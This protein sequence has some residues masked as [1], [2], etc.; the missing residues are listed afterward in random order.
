[1]L[2]TA[3]SGQINRLPGRTASQS[4]QFVIYSSDRPLRSRVAERAEA[5]RSAWRSALGDTDEWKYPIVINF[6]DPAPGRTGEGIVTGIY[7]ADNNALKVQVDVWDP[8]RGDRHDFTV[9]IV[10]ALALERT[11]RKNP[12]R[13]GA[14]FR[15]APPWLVEGI[16]E[17]FR[18]KEEGAPAKLYASLLDAAG[19]QKLEALLKDKPA[20]MDTTSRQIYR[21]RSMA[22][23]RAL[24]DL[25]D[26]QKGLVSYLGDLGAF[27]EGLQGLMKYFPSLAGDA[28]NL[29]KV[30]TLA[31]ARASATDRVDPLSMGETGEKLGQILALS[32][33]ADPKKRD[34]A[35]VQGALALG[36]IARGE[37]GRYTLGQLQ[38]SL[39]RLEF[40]A[41]PLY[42]ALVADYRTIVQSL[43]ERPKRSQDKRIAEDEELRGALAKRAGQIEDYINWFEAAKLDQPSGEFDAILDADRGGGARRTDAISRYLDDVESR[44]W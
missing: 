23:V 44:G 20:L 14:A 16:A 15:Y 19:T 25:G 30:W 34:G 17:D 42:R 28:R 3:A 21:A 10:R 29:S 26:G 4:G 36:A 31:L 43:I 2:A 5:I 12:L 7:E 24:L 9:E 13:S 6:P 35:K 37:T 1:V 32:A 22:L 8:G 40:R 41:H 18:A 11:Y 33:P 27:D 39:F 38:E